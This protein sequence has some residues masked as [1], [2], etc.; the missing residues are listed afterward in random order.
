MKAKL[1]PDFP[2][3]EWRRKYWDDRIGYYRCQFCGGMAYPGGPFEERDGYL[4]PVE[5][6]R[7]LECDAE[8]SRMEEVTEE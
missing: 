4:W 6:P 7:C 8:L 3:E 2:R 1:H 5:P